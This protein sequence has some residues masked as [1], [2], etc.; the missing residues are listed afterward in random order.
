MEA[1]PSTQYSVLSIQYRIKHSAISIQPLVFDRSDGKTNTW[2][3]GS[4]SYGYCY[5]VLNT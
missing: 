1:V 5:R 2:R 4:L 3:Q